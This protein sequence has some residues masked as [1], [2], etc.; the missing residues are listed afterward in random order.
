MWVQP[1]IFDH[2]SPNSTFCL[3]FQICSDFLPV[4]LCLSR[5]CWSH[6]DSVLAVGGVA[7]STQAVGA[8]GAS[9]AAAQVQAP[10]VDPEAEMVG[11]CPGDE[12]HGE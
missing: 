5:P 7:T 10:G 12:A 9:L 6:P 2:L 8:G 4:S 11:G 3:T 1:A